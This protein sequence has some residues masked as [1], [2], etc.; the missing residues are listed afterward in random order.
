VVDGRTRDE[1]T[2]LRPGPVYTHRRPV[3]PHM[4]AAKIHALDT[5]VMWGVEAPHTLGNS[6]A[7]SDTSGLKLPATGLRQAQRGQNHYPICTRSEDA[8]P[9]S[10]GQCFAQCADQKREQCGN[11]ATGVVAKALA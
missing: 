9:G 10:D 2:V 4:M 6:Q 8:D 1:E 3:M 5:V 11:G 7:E